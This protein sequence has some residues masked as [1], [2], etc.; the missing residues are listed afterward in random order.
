MYSLFH[1]RSLYFFSHTDPCDAIDCQSGYECQI[2]NETGEAFCSPNCEDLD[3]CEPQEQCV[4]T[5][6]TC[7]RAPCPGVLSCEPGKVQSYYYS[8]Y[9]CTWRYMCLAC[10]CTC[11]GMYMYMY[12][13]MLRRNHSKVNLFMGE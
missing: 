11:I 12:M 9:S 6:V 2:F 13:C 4:I 3:P 5:A 1:C 7:V 10:T 8:L